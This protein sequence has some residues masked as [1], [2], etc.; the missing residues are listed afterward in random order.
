MTLISKLISSEN[1]T[2]QTMLSN[3]QKGKNQKPERQK[4]SNF[5]EN[6]LIKMVVF[7]YEKLYS[8]TSN[9]EESTKGN[10]KGYSVYNCT[11]PPTISLENYMKRIHSYLEFSDE[12]LLLALV[13]IDKLMQKTCLKISSQNIHK[14]SFFIC[15]ISHF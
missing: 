4:S 10:L 11:F 9:F 7:L 13:Y 12:M 3:K 15:V 1:N 6:S 14:L 2:L 8:I 5:H